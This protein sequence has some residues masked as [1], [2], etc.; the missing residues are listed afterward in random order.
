MPEIKGEVDLIVAGPSCQGFSMAGRRNI[1]DPRNQLFGNW[2]I[3]E[4]NHLKFFL[5]EN[6]TGLL[7]MDGGIVN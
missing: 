6:V 3:V 7:S 1:D 5:G 2:Y 4:E